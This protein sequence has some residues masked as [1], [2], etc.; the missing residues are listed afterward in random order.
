MINKRHILAAACLSL[1]AACGQNDT[2]ETTAPAE[3]PAATET[4]SPDPARIEAHMAYLA[5]DDLLGREAGTPGYDEAAAYVAAQF[6]ELGLA[7][8]GD[9]GS[10]MQAVPLRRSYRDAEG[11]SLSI[12]GPDGALALEENVDYIVFGS[13]AAEEAAIEAEAVFVGFGVV[14][15]EE[16]RDD[17]AGLDVDGK[18]VVV[19]SGTPKN[20]QSE[21]RAFY[22]SRKGKNASDRGA[23][24]VLS[25][26][27]ETSR[28]IYPFAR[29]VGENRADESSMS[30][31]GPDGETFTLA[32]NL[33]ASARLSIEGA[34]KFFAAAGADWSEISA[35]AEEETGAVA[36][37][38]LPF[39]VAISHKS[40]LDTIQS[41]NVAGMIEGADP[42]L[43]DEVIVLTAHLDHIGVSKTFEDDAINNGALD[44]AAGIAT[45]FEAARV[46]QAGP[47]PR[48]SVMFL[49]VTAEEKGLLGAQYF[50][51]NPTV[52][53]E[54]IVANVNLDM[55]VLT[56]AFT[57][58][59]VFGG[60]RSTIN[61]AIETAA[62]ELDVT[63][64]PDP[65][66]DQGIFTR[67]DH[68]RFVEIGVPSVM[69]STGFANGGDAAWATHFA[70]NYHRPSDDMDN[71]LDF[72]AA[73][74]FADI[75]ARIAL[76]LANAD[77]R[78]LWRKDDFFARQFNGPMEE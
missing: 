21:E 71:T 56:Y 60:T 11:V 73:A 65:F 50:A 36:G 52:P 70:E 46:I 17:Y 47:A 66:P 49:A 19:L 78:P 54:N 8:A 35:A 18:I 9:E 7:P 75:K 5:S 2:P 27:T 58:L 68:F 12:A 28:G 64:G 26:E 16:G 40:T 4:V 48:R 20:L 42:A 6:E 74:K 67:S 31:I 41:A 22:G 25:I 3:I 62:A 59:I 1:A 33:Q 10:Y 23:I 63:L 51:Q 32:P 14:A 24:G 37:F 45:L 76:T 15:P 30:W 29:L 13:T 34:E 55:P 77:E 39:T 61:D 69:L 43:K 53:A 44:N 38:A 57:D 72:E